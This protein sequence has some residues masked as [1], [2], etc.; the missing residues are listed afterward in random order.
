M[1]PTKP[2]CGTCKRKEP[3][4]GHSQ[5]ISCWLYSDDPAFDENGDPVI[6]PDEMTPESRCPE[7]GEY[8][9]D[10]ICR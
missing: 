1:E 6:G 5:C 10:C 8:Y 2:L 7:C 9:S 3:M 4:N